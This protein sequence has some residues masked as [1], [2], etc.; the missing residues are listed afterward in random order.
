MVFRR[1]SADLCD[2]SESA[3]RHQL[4]GR[5]LARQD[6]FLR[7][8]SSIQK[9]FCCSQLGWHRETPARVEEVVSAVNALNRVATTRLHCI[10]LCNSLG[11]MELFQRYG[12]HC[13]W[14]HQNAFLDERKY[15][16]IPAA[17]KRYDAIYVARIT[18]FKRHHLAGQLTSLCLVGDHSGGRRLF[19]SG[20][21][22]HVAGPLVSQINSW[23]SIK[24]LIRARRALPFA[25]EG[26]MFV[27]AEYLLCGLPVVSTRNLGGRDSL[28]PPEC[29]DR[30]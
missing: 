16:I 28:F 27:S 9:L 17:V 3:D 10:V 22:C 29:H 12:L 6:D 30:G 25:E 18:P 13:R 1:L 26:A 23:I 5:F 19:Q 4:L 15:R 7:A 8:L 11:E 14:C 24:C 20:H 2:Q 21:G